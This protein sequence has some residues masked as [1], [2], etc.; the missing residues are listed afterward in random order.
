MAKYSFSYYCDQGIRENNQDACFISENK[1]GQVFAIVCDGV[2]SEKHSEV[3][4]QIA[5][6]MAATEF[7]NTQNIEFKSFFYNFAEDAQ[8]KI[9]KTMKEEYPGKPSSTTVACCLLD[10]NKA[11]VA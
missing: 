2:G 7:I 10:N 1:S 6:S 9:I 11:H 4:S 8:K 3:A 5:I